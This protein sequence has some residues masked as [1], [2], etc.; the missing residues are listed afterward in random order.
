MCVMNWVEVIQSRVEHNIYISH[1]SYNSNCI[2]ASFYGI[3]SVSY[4][5]RV[6]TLHTGHILQD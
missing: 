4:G 5:S 2:R 6:T 1:H 3:I